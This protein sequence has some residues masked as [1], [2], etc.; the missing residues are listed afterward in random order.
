MCAPT[1]I[2]Q[3]FSFK[4]AALC[5]HALHWWV[6]TQ[7]VHC[8]LLSL[9]LPTCLLLPVARCHCAAL[10]L[11]LARNRGNAI[12]FHPPPVPVAAAD[13]SLLLAI[14][15]HNTH[16]AS[17]AGVVFKTVMSYEINWSLNKATIFNE[18][19][20]FMI[21]YAFNFKTHRELVIVPRECTKALFS[22]L[23]NSK[24]FHSLSPSH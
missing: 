18:E 16:K 14:A 13:F 11:S 5:L 4:S 10:P 21:L 20:H 7:I 1:L 23:P 2:N 22:S 24:F 3:Y 17:L 15:R 8:F 19:F 9:M 6:E 12:S